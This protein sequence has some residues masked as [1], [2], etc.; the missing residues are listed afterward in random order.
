MG[1]GSMGC[2]LHP[3]H[4]WRH[5]PDSAPEARPRT[6]RRGGDRLH[7]GKFRS[8]GILT[9]PDYARIYSLTDKGRAELSL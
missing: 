4:P 3:E 5:A 6:L 7:D 1:T 8:Q 9:W 2:A